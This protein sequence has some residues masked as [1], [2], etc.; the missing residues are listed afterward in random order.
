MV[1]YVK[2]Y[3]RNQLQF[4]NA[5]INVN[6]ERATSC[7]LPSKFNPAKYAFVLERKKQAYCTCI[8]VDLK[9]SRQ[10]FA[11]RPTASTRSFIALQGCIELVE[12]VVAHSRMHVVSGER[13]GSVS[14]DCEKIRRL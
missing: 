8:T 6:A 11:L 13:L 12:K 4:S 14:C 9:G 5:V 3:L 10:Y 7:P 1:G 2:F